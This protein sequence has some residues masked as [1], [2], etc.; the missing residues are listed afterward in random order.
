MK[1]ILTNNSKL[2]LIFVLFITNIHSLKLNNKDNPILPNKELKTIKILF[3][4]KFGVTN[5]VNSLTSFTYKNSVFSSDE[6]EFFEST[7]S[8]EPV[9]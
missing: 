7:L 9:I 2:L 5:D 8:S 3:R 4:Y 1:L 6:L